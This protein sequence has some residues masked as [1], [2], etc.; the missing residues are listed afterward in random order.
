MTND[1]RKTQMQ[2]KCS[3]P[4]FPGSASCPAPPGNSGSQELTA[5]PL[6]PPVVGRIMAAKDVLVLIAGIREYVTLHG[7]NDFAEYGF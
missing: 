1:H 4:V 5:R 2:D 3:R 6:C 7:K